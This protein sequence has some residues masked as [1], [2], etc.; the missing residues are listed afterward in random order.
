MAATRYE[1]PSLV[2]QVT[3]TKGE[4]TFIVECCGSRA[5]GLTW[6]GVSSEVLRFTDPTTMAFFQADLE[7]ELRCDGWNLDISGL[8]IPGRSAAPHRQMEV[9]VDSPR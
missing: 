1:F 4:D 7:R 3:Y 2:A 5:I 8:Q 6:V 9:V